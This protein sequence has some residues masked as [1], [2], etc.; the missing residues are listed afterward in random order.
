ML[1]R[2]LTQEIPEDGIITRLLVLPLQPR[3]L[4]TIKTKQQG[5][6]INFLINTNR[7][8]IL[9]ESYKS[10]IRSI[11]LQQQQLIFRRLVVRDLDE[12]YGIDKM[13]VWILH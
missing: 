12:L 9:F 13:I 11:H 5:K 8:G 7:I 1:Q 6:Q 2:D 4:K 3:L 10:E